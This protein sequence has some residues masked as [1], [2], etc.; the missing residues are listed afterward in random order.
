MTSTRGENGAPATRFQRLS[1]ALPG[2]AANN[3]VQARRGSPPSER[4]AAMS[5]LD[6]VELKLA[7]AGLVIDAILSAFVTYYLAADHPTREVTTKG[8]LSHLR[9]NREGID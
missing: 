3:P 5:S 7:N 4:R 8:Q 1:Q 9:I 6:A 2:P